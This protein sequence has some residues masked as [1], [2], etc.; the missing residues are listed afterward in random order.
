MRHKDV[1]QRP[2]ENTVIDI[3]VPEYF[4]FRI[5]DTLKSLPYARPLGKPSHGAREMVSDKYE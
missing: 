1:L 2:S 3:S 4:R 5:S